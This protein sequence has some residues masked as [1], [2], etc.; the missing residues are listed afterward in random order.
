MASKH[1]A[2]ENPLSAYHAVVTMD[3]ADWGDEAGS[4]VTFRLP[5]DGMEDQRNPFEKYTKR[6]KGKAG[7]RFYL[8]CTTCDS[9]PQKLYMDEAMLAG[10]NDS[11]SKGHTV[12]FWLCND[13]M[14]HP[15]DGISRSQSLA[16]ALAELDDDNEAIDQ[17]MRDRVEQQSIHPHSRPS[18]VA[19]M[20]CKNEGFWTW[21]GADDED[22]AKQE[23]YDRLEIGSRAE[24]DADPVLAERFHTEIRRPF[25]RWQVE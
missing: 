16:V 22:E 14:G 2:F 25:L 5:M 13:A 3:R 24:L 15:F 6:R 18:Y 9:E 1:P 4:T 7:T 8:A 11:Q 17:N 19:A 12:K 23:I 20:L 21:L 10:W